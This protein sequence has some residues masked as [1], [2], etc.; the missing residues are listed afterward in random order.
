[1][2]VQVCSGVQQDEKLEI[3]LPKHARS[4]ADNQGASAP[5]LSIAGLSMDGNVLTIERLAL[6]IP[7][8]RVQQLSCLRTRGTS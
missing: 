7:L 1:M 5:E 6:P 3:D 4:Q 8:S 2:K